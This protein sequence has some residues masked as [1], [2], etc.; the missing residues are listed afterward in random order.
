MSHYYHKRKIP[1]IYR[2][3]EPLGWS[4]LALILAWAYGKFMEASCGLFVSITKTA[5]CPAEEMPTYLFWT[6]A[7]L[8][9]YGF[10]GFAY[11]AYRDFY[12]GDY[13]M[14]HPHF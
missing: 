4:A 14:D 10:I 2:C 13:W 12:K 1:N 11:K 6:F 7:A 8:F 3:L 5:S 9:I